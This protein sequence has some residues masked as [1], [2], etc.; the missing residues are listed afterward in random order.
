MIESAARVWD[1][2]N[3]V[4]KMSQI[5]YVVMRERHQ[6]NP[7]HPQ[8]YEYIGR[9]QA[10][11]KDRFFIGKAELNPDQVRVLFDKWVR[12]ENHSFLPE[13]FVTRCTNNPNKW[14]KI[15]KEHRRKMEKAA[16]YICLDSQ[17]QKVR[18]V[19]V[20]ANARKAQDNPDLMPFIEGQDQDGKMH[21][22]SEE[23]VAMNIT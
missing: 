19:A 20:G 14:V 10:L 8:V 22:L 4:R 17:I 6:A 7:L 3:F 15:P 16:K 18:K 23:W 21:M 1:D 2:S 9:Q 5:Q 13:A 12:N 11:K